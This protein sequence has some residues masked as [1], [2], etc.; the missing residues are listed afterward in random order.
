MRVAIARLGVVVGIALL[1][2]CG[3][4]GSSGG[5]RSASTSAPIGSST[6]SP[7]TS[8]TPSSNL[9]S[10]TLRFLTYNVAGLPQII[11]QVQPA[12]NTPLISPKLNGY[13]LVVV[14]EDFVYHTELAKDATHPYQSPPLTGYSTLV[15]DGLN[16]FSTHPFLLRA[17]V[18]WSVFHGLTSNSNDGLSSKGFS[19]ARHTLGPGVEVD[20]YNLHADAGGDQGDIDARIVQYDQLA[21]F[22]EAFSAG[23]ALIVA[24]DTNLNTWSGTRPQDDT[25]LVTFMTRLGLTDAAR[26]LGGQESLDRV[27]LRSSAD[28]ELTAK[29]WR[30][31]TEFVD[32]AGQPLSDHDAIHVDIGW[33]RLR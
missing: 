6:T 31:A 20:V 5:G 19:C 27:M 14:Q 17:R 18:K 26:T 8:G 12:T 29:T 4:S 30:F 23:R 9:P 11:S 1:A 22:I 13:E 15:G 24:G 25:T 7:T 16:T 10:G 2:G 21:D 32:A 28:V 3:G 33:R